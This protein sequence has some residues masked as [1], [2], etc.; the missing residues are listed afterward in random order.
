[1]SYYQIADLEK[2][3]GIKAHTIRIWEKRYGVI[4]PHRTTTNIRYYDDNQAKKLLKISTL[5]ESGLKIS[6]I[7]ELSE[8]EINQQ[9]QN[10]QQVGN[11]DVICTGYINELTS[12][13][14][15]FDEA[16][17]E[18]TF[19]NA[20][21]KFGM[22]PAM[23]KVFY[24]FL[25]KTGMMWS[26]AETMPVQEHFATSIIRRKLISAID[27]LPLAQKK[28]KRFVLFLPPEEWHETGLLLS[29]YIIRSQGYPT[30]Y[31]GQNVPLEN[32]KEVIKEA[33]PTHLFTLYVTRKDLDQVQ[34]EL[35]YISK[36][37]SALKILLAG[38][39]PVIQSVKKHKNIQVLQNPAD[40]LKAL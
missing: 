18:K 15:S 1:M 36:H 37:Y 23:I 34:T 20:V 2:L 8:K 4:K 33:K 26:M 3:S 24:P 10:I 29:D 25:H 7:A 27:G 28:S 35:Q 39:Q 16:L 31:L 30:I 9:I 32:L 21:V 22:Y 11:D 17:F 12:A 13:M 5:L 19:S 14:L 6:R 40:L 38:S